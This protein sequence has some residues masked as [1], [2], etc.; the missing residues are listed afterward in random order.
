[1]AQDDVCQN[2]RN[3]NIGA[4]IKQRTIM[5]VASCGLGINSIAGIIHAINSGYVFDEILFANTGRGKKFG[6]RQATYDYLKIFN[7]W[8]TKHGQKEIKIVFSK[9]AKGKSISLYEEMYKLR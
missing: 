1:M 7:H 3:R 9:N 6:E 5:N 2:S 4:T 8:L